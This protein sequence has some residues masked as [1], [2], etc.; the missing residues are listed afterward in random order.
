MI[1]VKVKSLRLVFG[2][3]WLLGVLRLS[4][5]TPAVQEA[6]SVPLTIPTIRFSGPFRSFSGD[7]YLMGTVG[8]D[9]AVYR[10]DGSNGTLTGQFPLSS[11]PLAGKT[12]MH[13]SPEVAVDT[14]GNIFLA[15]VWRPEGTRQTSTGIFVLDRNGVY[16]R[17][18]T[19]SPRVEARHLTIDR[20]GNLYVLGMNTDY[21]SGKT[22]LCMMIHKYTPG[23]TRV[24]AFSDCP[25]G[26]SLRNQTGLTPGPDLS[27][28]NRDI[29]L[30]SVW[31]Q[32]GLIYHVLADLHTVKTFDTSGRQVKQIQFEPPSAAL[33]TPADPTV[34]SSDEIRR[35]VP[36]SGGRFMLEWLHA[37][38]SGSTRHSGR[39]L[40]IHDT[41][42][43]LLTSAFAPA[44]ASAVLFSDEAGSAYMLRRNI[45][46]SH[47]LVRVNVSV[48]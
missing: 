33:T 3:L 28:L 11:L 20:E 14:D 45:S 12:M 43:K 19:L 27:K 37:D 7:L 17:T 15:A 34:A 46:A 25:A 18:I 6:G 41:D 44:S 16:T 5:G 23:G 1:D 26:Y 9:R 24:T 48:Q 8:N 22:D 10:Y 47:E 40:S 42:G 31:F 39:V 21:F 32:N 13:F 36:I 30:G 29:N 38:V 2:S 35:V 4:A